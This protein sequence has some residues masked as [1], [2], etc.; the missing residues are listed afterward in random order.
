M[1]SLLG[2]TGLGI[3]T[4]VSMKNRHLGC[5]ANPVDLQNFR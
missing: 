2:N 1:E 4:V 3:F 5:N